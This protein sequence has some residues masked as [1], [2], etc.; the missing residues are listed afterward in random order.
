VITPTGGIIDFTV[1]LHETD[2]FNRQSV[3]TATTTD[4]G[5]VPFIQNNP[6]PPNKALFDK[7]VPGWDGGMKV[8]TTKALSQGLD[9]VTFISRFTSPTGPVN[10][11]CSTHKEVIISASP[12]PPPD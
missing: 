12:L 8:V 6:S 11:L 1:K 7:T 5:S 3:Q 4:V 9:T 10:T 2:T